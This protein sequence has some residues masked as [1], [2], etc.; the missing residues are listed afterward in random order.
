MITAAIEGVTERIGTGKIL[1]DIT[2]KQISNNVKK[3]LILQS[4]IM[5]EIAENIANAIKNNGKAD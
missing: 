1:S 2:K 3:E 4:N 5:L